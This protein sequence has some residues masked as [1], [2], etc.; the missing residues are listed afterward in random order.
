MFCR[1]VRSKTVL[2]ALSCAV[3]ASRVGAVET[4]SAPLTVI[5]MDPLSKRLACACVKDYAQ[6]DYA[7]LGDYLTAKLGRPVRI[8]EG[9]TLQKGLMQAEK[10]SVALII[11]KDSVARH[12]APGEGLSLRPLAQ[13]S[14]QDGK[15]TLTGLFVVRKNDAA[16]DLAA[17]AGREFFFGSEAEIEKHGA[18]LDALRIAGVP[19]PAELQTRAGC[20]QAILDLIDST[21]NPPPVAVISSYALPL[22]TGCGISDKE[23]LRVIGETKP[24][25]FIT[26]FATENLDA[27]TEAKV[28]K[29]L[30]AVRKDKAL[31][32]MMETKSGFVPAK[33]KPPAP[34]TAVTVDW[35]QWLGPGR[36]GQAAWLPEVLPDPPRFIWRKQLD[37]PGLAGLV[38]SGGRVIVSGRDATGKADVFQCMD[39]A[40]GRELWRLTYAAEGELDY[41]ASPRA[42]P[43]I[44]DGCVYLFGAFGH[45]H[46]VRLSDGVV[47]W[48]KDICKT[49]NARPPKWGYAASP[50]AV[51]G[52][53]ILAPGGAEAS[54]VAL[55]PKTGREIWRCAG[56]P[57]AYASFVHATAGGHQELIGYDESTL[58]GWELQTGR[59]LW[60]IRPENEG[61]FNVPTPQIVDG[62]LFVATENNG[63]RLYD[64][65]PDGTI[66]PSPVAKND[67]LSPDS[68][69][70]VASGRFIV[71]CRAGLQCLDHRSGLTPAA[72]SG[73]PAFSE[74]ASI[75]AAGDRVLVTTR[76]GEMLLVRVSGERCEILGRQFPFGEG[77]EIYSAP[78]L[79]GSRLF[80]RNNHEIACFELTP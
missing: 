35:P 40:S 48:K 9:E 46:C 57:A 44:L 79:V 20:N 53:L 6:R 54:L 49:F 28:V 24:A 41:G 67:L 43:L 63:A 22:V 1:F 17:L 66:K 12:D 55:D 10:S 38:V 13:L 25:P 78:A 56:R 52:K 64:F 73:D 23:S 31:R 80:L 69:T 70:P 75:I 5:V 77:G 4:S 60:E 45:F 58:G 47:Q 39:A 21:N 18:A 34:K 36:N 19:P 65:N 29:A 14:G 8:V 7:A 61:D 30:L 50:L 68:A 27:T 72:G 59:R 26:V 3:V 74:F 71:G 62:R 37:S 33:P 11:A 32:K 15:T 51:D 76:E 16:K 42:T 2:L